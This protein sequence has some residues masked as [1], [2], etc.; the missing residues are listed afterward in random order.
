MDPKIE[1]LAQA[2]RTIRD[3]AD[4]ALKEIDHAGGQR[5]ALGWKCSG[6]GQIKHFTRAVPV[7]VAVPCPKCHGVAFKQC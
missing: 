3:R 4:A 6:C 7:E 1:T 2:L 5:R